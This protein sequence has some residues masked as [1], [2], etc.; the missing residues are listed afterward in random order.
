VA[1]EVYLVEL[2]GDE[3]RLTHTH[4]TAS[5]PTWAPN[6]S[7]LA[8]ITADVADEYA[9]SIRTVRSDGGAQRR[10]ATEAN[11]VHLD[12]L[13]WSPDGDRMAYSRTVHR[14][15]DD[16]FV[17]IGSDGSDRRALARPTPGHFGAEKLANGWGVVW[18]PDG[19]KLAVV[20]G[21]SGR[22]YVVRADQFGL[23]GSLRRVLKD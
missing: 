22:I 2:N 18:S 5:S 3:K 19:T 12:D 14:S 11:T 4:G 23:T 6:G 20:K 21:R 7:Q 8:F 17:V 15:N 13:T 10:I 9:S 1:G 16:E